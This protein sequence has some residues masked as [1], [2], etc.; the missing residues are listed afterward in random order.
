MSIPSKIVVLF[1]VLWATTVRADGPNNF[2]SSAFFDGINN[3]L[4]HGGPPASSY[5]L[6]E[7]GVSNL[8]LEDGSSFLCLEGGC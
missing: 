8:L 5:L 6:L 4:K 3:P 7:D 2:T 1:I